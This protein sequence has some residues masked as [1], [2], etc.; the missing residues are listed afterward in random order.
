M[1]LSESKHNA[2]APPT[3]PLESEAFAKSTDTFVCWLSGAGFLIHSRG[4]NVMIDPDIAMDKEKTDTVEIGLRMRVP[5]PIEAKDVP[6]LDAVIYTHG[7]SD[8]VGKYTPL[9]LAEKDALFYG[10]LPVVKNIESLGV[11]VEQTK[12]IGIGETFKIGQIEITTTPAEHPWQEKNPE[13]YG[14]PWGP[15]DC[16]GFLIKTPDGTI[17]CTG[18]TRLLPEHLE[19]TGIDVLLLDVSRDEYHLGPEAA[20]IANKLSHAQLI[21]YHY[22]TYDTEIE[23]LNGNP[24]ELA[25]RISEWERRLH[26]LAPGE[27]FEVRGSEHNS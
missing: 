22:G 21:P 13:K 10:T 25:P 7:D 20:T 16:C 3:Q 1:S 8:H 18:D 6:R 9:A 19:M 27:K 17:W 24:M 11:P 4:T 26:V 15:N 5:L 23:A 12:T 2:G 14:Q